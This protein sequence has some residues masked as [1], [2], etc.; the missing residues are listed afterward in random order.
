MA[1]M[2]TADHHPDI[3]RYAGTAD[4]GRTLGVRTQTVTNW[5]NRYPPGSSHPCPAPDVVV[6]DVLGWEEGRLP[7]WEAWR[8]GMPGR[9]AGGGRPRKSP[10]E[11]LADGIVSEMERFER[12]RDAE[13]RAEEDRRRQVE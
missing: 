2:A 6:G 4:V 8:A 3:P 9:G 10:A 12:A 1:H 7:E 5:L 13:E 11:K